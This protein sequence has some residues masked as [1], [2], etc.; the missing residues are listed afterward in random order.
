MKGKT[1]PQSDIYEKSKLENYIKENGKDYNKN[2]IATFQL[3]PDTEL[4]TDIENK[5][6]KL[7][8]EIPP[9]KEDEKLG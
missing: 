9:H 8:Y 5:L 1:E 6:R 3:Q 7:L 2:E 4:L